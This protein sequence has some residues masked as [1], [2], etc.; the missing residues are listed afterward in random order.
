MAFWIFKCNPQHYRIGARLADPSS[1][2][3]W[4]VTRYRDEIQPG[5]TV[6]LWVTGHDRGIR[7]VLRVDEAPRLMAELD[8]EQV[9]W[10]EEDR[11]EKWRM[12]GLLTHRS[13]NLFHTVLRKTPGLEQLSIF[14]GFQQATNFPVTPVEGMIL[15]G[16]IQCEG[17]A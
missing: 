15:M 1:L 16:L 10:I 9:Y 7:A 3:T 6:F 11:E 8:C 2:I 5:D 17:K 14:H 12:V 13:V 4:N